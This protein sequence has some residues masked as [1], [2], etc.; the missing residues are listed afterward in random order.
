MA[1]GYFRAVAVD[2]DGTLTEGA[3]PDEAVLA[4]IADLRRRGIRV[5]LA[6]GRI[7]GELRRGFHDV[8]DHFD[9]IVA[10]NGALLSGPHGR[11]L[12]AD[13]VDAALEDALLR[14]RVPVR[15]GEVL[16][17]CD[18]THDLVV[19]EEIGRLGLD[20]QILRNR[21]ALMVLPAGVTKGSGL[22]EAL[23]D[24]GV[25]RH[26]TITA[27]DAENDRRLLEVGEYGVA[28]ANA[29]DALKD[30]A[31]LVLDEADGHGI[32]GLLRGPILTGA[33]RAHSDRWRVLLGMTGE[34]ESVVIP[35]SQVNV[36]IAGGSGMGKS[37]VAGLLAEAISEL[38]YSALVVD[39]EG[40]HLGLDDLRGVLSVGGVEPLPKPTEIHRLLRHRFGSVVLDLSL[41]VP[42]EQDAY[43]SSLPEVIEDER[44]QTGLPHWVFVDEAHRLVGTDLMGAAVLDEANRG[45]CLVS[46]RPEHLTGISPENLDVVLLTPGLEPHQLSSLAVA[47]GRTGQH[48]TDLLDGT[49]VG[50]AI[51]I[52]PPRGPDHDRCFTVASRRTSHVRH[53]HKYVRL[54]LDAHLH[55][56]F[57]TTGNVPTGHVATSLYE[58]HHILRQS[59]PEVIEH[60][61]SQHD[62]SCWIQDA[63]KDGALQDSFRATERSLAE[64]GSTSIRD[65]LVH[66]IEQRY[67]DEV[68]AEQVD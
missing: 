60:H 49:V 29:V 39:L 58:F 31:D 48:L 20:C 35:A 13:P 7:L 4:A 62:F 37:Y 59:P 55:F 22:L 41:L 45:Y 9:S 56:H 52:E 46:Y 50:Q 3:R 11:R 15:S 40:D 26:S 12:L 23:G 10:E 61:A 32:L 65:E 51:I 14:R 25:S 38:G 53:W 16:L 28:V 36:L 44:D 43:I 34:G 19:L 33:R 2:F 47:T 6:T 17:A 8:D 64:A 30:H 68:I 18:A 21:A 57:R 5:I 54:P 63:I 27:G 1:A 24:L 42:D 66:A 67:L